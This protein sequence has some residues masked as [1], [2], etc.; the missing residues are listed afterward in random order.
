MPYVKWFLQTSLST[1]SDQLASAN[2]VHYSHIFQ[3]LQAAS[4]FL[5][6]V[7]KALKVIP[8]DQPIILPVP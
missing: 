1:K 5:I 4:T 6:Q 2:H 3:H 7:A 8:H